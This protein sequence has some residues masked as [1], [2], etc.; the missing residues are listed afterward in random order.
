MKVFINSMIA[1]LAKKS[2]LIASLIFA[3][4][5]FVLVMFVIN[6]VIDGGNGIG[7]IQLQLSF[8]KLAGIKIIESWGE[9][10]IQRF[11]QWIFTDYIY[12]FSYAL[13]LASILST[14][15]IK[16][17]LVKVSIYKYVPLMP[18]LAG[19]LDWLE[20]SMELFFMHDMQG[21]SEVLFT[22]H[23][24]VASAKFAFILL[25]FI[26]IIIFWAKKKEHD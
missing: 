21:Y 17:R 26:F 25:S 3:S 5:M 19:L 8:D 14:L 15:I 2:T 10:A 11:K 4:I 13:F 16:S 7:V 6:P 22:I 23:S 20:D 1:F 24:L 18:F 9:G 12:A